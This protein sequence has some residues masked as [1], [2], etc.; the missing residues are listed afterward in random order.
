MPLEE[1]VEE[2]SVHES[3]SR[4]QPNSNVSPV[5]CEPSVF[6]GWGGP[7]FPLLTAEPILFKE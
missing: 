1:G 3:A 6:H 5:F 4:L 2:G 7:N